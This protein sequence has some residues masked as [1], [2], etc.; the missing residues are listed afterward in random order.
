MDTDY[1]SRSTVQMS[2]E[3][4]LGSYCFKKLIHSGSNRF[5]IIA[6]CW[7][8]LPMERPSFER[9]QICLQDFYA[10]LTRYV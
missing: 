2:C 5:A 10:Q 4:L 1:R 6:Y 8:M 9:L 3:Y 7:T